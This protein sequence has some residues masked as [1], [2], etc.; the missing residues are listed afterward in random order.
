MISTRPGFF[1]NVMVC[2]G[3][4]KITEKW[5]EIFEEM[6]DE[7]MITPY[8]TC[9]RCNKILVVGDYVDGFHPYHQEYN[10]CQEH[11]NEFRKELE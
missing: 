11:K 5:F 9:F 3:Q 6:N 4:E 1:D 7:G 10:V 2:G 8:P